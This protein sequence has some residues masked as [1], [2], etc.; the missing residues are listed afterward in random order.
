MSLYTQ[1]IK[2]WGIEGQLIKLM[3][4]AA[5]LIQ[6]CNKKRMKKSGALSHLAEEMVDVEILITQL[7]T[8]LNLEKHTQVW[9]ARKLRKLELRLKTD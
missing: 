1:A 8:A 4:E 5:E 9:K 7:R 3:E 6:A 2:K